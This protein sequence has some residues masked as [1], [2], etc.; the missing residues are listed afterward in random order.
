MGGL[1]VSWLVLLAEFP[2][3]RFGFVV[4]DGADFMW[5]RF[6]AFAGF[7]G[8]ILF[9]VFDTHGSAGRALDG[10]SFAIG[11]LVG[12]SCAVYTCVGALSGVFLVLLVG[13]LEGGH[14]SCLGKLPVLIGIAK[15][16]QMVDVLGVVEGG[17]ICAELLE[18]AVI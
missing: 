7:G 13:G 1:W 17:L 3:G 11:P 18:V 2:G 14:C 6:T 15:L 8:V 4:V 9:A 12:W 16:D 10:S 5:L